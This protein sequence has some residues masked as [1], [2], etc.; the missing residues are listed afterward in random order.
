[1]TALLPAGAPAAA[2]GD[3]DAL[4]RLER[5]WNEAHLHSDA[6]ALESLWADDFVVIVPRMEVI[7]RATAVAMA[8]SGRL[9]F[10]RYETSDVQARIYGA[11][12]IV[13]GRLQRARKTNDKLV[14]DDWQFTKIY[15]RSGDDWKVVL[16]QAS[17]RP[18]PADPAKTR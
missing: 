3:T 13:T 7:T 10:E 15:V 11:T 4:L 6:T 2:T 5:T 9:R 1:M 12:G 18:E 17:E 14:D 16:F 8:R